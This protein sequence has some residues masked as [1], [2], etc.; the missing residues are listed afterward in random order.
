VTEQTIASG[1]N[2]VVNVEVLEDLDGGQRG[3]R[4]D[5]LLA[6]GLGVQVADV[7]VHVEDVAVAQTLDILGDINY[8]LQVLILAVVEDR[9]VDNNAV[10][11]VVGVGGEDGAF[12]IVAGN[13]TEGVLEAAIR[14]SVSPCAIWGSSWLEYAIQFSAI[15]ARGMYESYMQ[16]HQASRK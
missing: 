8:L 15:S 12:N 5:A 6:L 7:L 10:D 1:K 4:Q 14:E 11:I 3:A 2:S 13:F 9:V 16:P